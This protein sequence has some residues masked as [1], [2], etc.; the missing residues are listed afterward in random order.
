MLS[1]LAGHGAA[2]GTL[3]RP[4]AGKLLR[5]LPKDK[6]GNRKRN[7]RALAEQYRPTRRA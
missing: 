6:R 5:A 4:A 3:L 1:K 2:Q 7:L